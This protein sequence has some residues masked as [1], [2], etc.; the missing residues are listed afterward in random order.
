MNIYTDMC[1]CVCV[2]VYVCVCVFACV[3]VCMCVC[4]CVYVSVCVC[5]CVVCVCVCVCVH[6]HAHL[7]GISSPVSLSTILCWKRHET[8]NIP[9]P[10]LTPI[11]SLIMDYDVM[12]EAITCM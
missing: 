10:H 8:V 12:W 1:V 11:I 9:L 4:V 6:V 2:C 5:V 7:T 3:C